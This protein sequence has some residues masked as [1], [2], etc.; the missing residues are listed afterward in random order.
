MDKII[1]EGGMPLKGNI[2][3]MGAKNSALPVMAASL[4]IQGKSVLHNVPDLRDVKTMVALLRMLGAKVQ[5]TES[6]SYL[7]DASTCNQFEAP[8]ELVKTMRASVVVMGPLVSR[9]LKARI[10]LPGGCAIGSR[11][12]DI[13][14]KGFEK[15]GAEITITHGYVEA[16]AE[17]LKGADITLD[18]PS[19]GA[20]ENIMMAASLADGKTV[21]KNAACEPEIKDLA[22]FLNTA[23]G[24]ICGAGTDT[25]EIHGVKELNNAEFSIIPDRIEAGTYLI[26]AAMTNGYVT[27]TPVITAHQESVLEKMAEAGIYL[28]KNGEGLTVY[29]KGTLL[30]INIKTMVFPGFPTDMQAQFMAMACI[31]EGTSIISETIFE[32]RFMHVPELVRMGANIRVEGSNAIIAGVPSLTGAHVMASDLRASAALVLA[33]LVANG[34]THIHRIYHIDRGYELFEKKLATLGA[35]IHRER[36]VSNEYHV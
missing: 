12:I 25:I 23:G 16:R 26:A 22:D 35:R 18:F 9:F 27:V 2:R 1:I 36:D 14:L 29:R 8:Y 34:A 30:P 6:H 15:L 28:E 21:I 33:G 32:N 11:P 20:T 13:H 5:K 10:S 7:I 3:V 31:A 24:N 4:L 19:V 17:K